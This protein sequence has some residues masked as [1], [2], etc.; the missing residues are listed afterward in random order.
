MDPN[1]VISVVVPLQNDAKLI[2]KMVED[3]D[4]VMEASFRFFE[5]ILVDDGSTDD[6][7]HVVAGILKNKQRIRY[8]RLS[9]SFGRDICLSAGI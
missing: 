3:L 6:T 5:L 4:R 7:R 1:T 2:S 9:R 8:Q